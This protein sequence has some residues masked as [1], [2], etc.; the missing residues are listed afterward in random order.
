MAVDMFLKLDGIMGESLDDKHKDEIVLESFSWGLSNP[1]A[2]N[3]A[4]GAGAGR[5]SFQDLHFTSKVSVASPKLMLHCATGEHIKTGQITFRRTDAQREGGFEFLFYKF[6]NILI[7]SIQEAGDTGGLPVD[8]VSIAFQ[9]VNIEYKPQTPAGGVGT[10]V[11][12]AWDL[13]AN[14]KV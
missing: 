6:D 2:H 7:T 13:A 10:A 9:K 3:I 8:S 11:D 5:A 12:F 14:K 4:S 1:G